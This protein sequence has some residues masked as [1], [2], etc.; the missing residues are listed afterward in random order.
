METTELSAENNALILSDN[1]PEILSDIPAELARVQVK[2]DLEIKELNLTKIELGK[3]SETKIDKS[4]NLTVLKVF[5]VFINLYFSFS[6]MGADEFCEIIEKRW[7]TERSKTSNSEQTWL[8]PQ[9]S[10][11][12]WGDSKEFNKVNLVCEIVGYKPRINNLNNEKCMHTFLERAPKSKLVL[13]ELGAMKDYL[14]V[15]ALLLDFLTSETEGSA[16][17]K[18]PRLVDLKEFQENQGLTYSVLDEVEV[19]EIMC[20]VSSAD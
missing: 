16:G 11:S 9:P 8:I 13:T 18:Y 12:S 3:G 15:E 6:V 4:Q 10:S 17:W 2:Y 19:R 20:G 1:Y 14:P 5:F 7:E